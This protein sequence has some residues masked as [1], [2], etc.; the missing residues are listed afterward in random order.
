[1][2]SFALEP[3]RADP[4]CEV[5][6]GPGAVAICAS[7]TGALSRIRR[8]LTSTL[9]LHDR[10]ALGECAAVMAAVA[11]NLR[12]AARIFAILTA[13]LAVSPGWAVASR[14]STLA[15]FL[16]HDRVLLA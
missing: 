8:K 14:V 16:R 9:R 12:C 15:G 5:V 6:T 7:T 10:P 4:Y 1:M 3:V 11:R 13:I 2:D